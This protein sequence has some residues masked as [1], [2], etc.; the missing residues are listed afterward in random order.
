MDIQYAKFLME[1]TKRDY[2]EI[3]EEFSATRKSMWPELGDLDKYAEEGDSVLDIGCGNGKLFGFLA[4][5]RKNFSYVGLD[6]SENLINIAK[7]NFK[8]ENAEFKVFDGIEIPYAENSFDIIYCLATLPHLPGREMQINF[9]ENVRKIAKPGA[10]L[11]ITCWN[12]WQFKFIKYQAKMIVNCITDK[13]L[14]KDEYDWGDLYIPWKKRGVPP[15][16]RFYHAFT[17]AELNSILKKA[18]WEVEEIGYKNRNGKKNFNLFA[19]AR[20]P[21]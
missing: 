17:L 3:A 19:V 12:L 15:I 11:I 4:E 21:I 18:G 1:K 7:Q 9:L 8:A 10:K 20:K 16:F 2:D 14:G 5:K 13:I 6:I